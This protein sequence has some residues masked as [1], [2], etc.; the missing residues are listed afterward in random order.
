MKRYIL[1]INLILIAAVIRYGVSSF[2]KVATAQLDVSFIAAAAGKK[3]SPAEIEAR[4]PLPFYQPIFESQLFG[5]TPEASRV[6]EPIQIDT[7]K[8]TQLKLKLW[9]TVVGDDNRT[10]AVIEAERAGQNLYRTGDTIQNAVIKLIL[11][12][13]VVLHVNG[14]DEILDMEKQLAGISTNI[15]HVQ[16]AP[17]RAQSIAFERSQIESAFQNPNQILQDIRV[18]PHFE[19]GKLDG[20]TITAIKPDSIFR[21][22]GLISGDILTNFNGEPVVSMNDALKFY[23]T[24]KTASTIKLDIKRRGQLQTIEYNIEP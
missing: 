19:K 20:L 23:E 12:E 17:S 24:I 11:R 16:P 14:R 6:P 18:R 13:K 10:Y 7:L 1:I 8:Q 15:S 9:G 3:T 21:K 2:Y 22:M 5:Q 4:R